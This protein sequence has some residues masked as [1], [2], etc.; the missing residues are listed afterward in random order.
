MAARDPA[1]EQRFGAAVKGL[2][3]G[4]PCYAYQELPSTMDAAHELAAHDAPEGTCVWAERQ[5]AGRGRSGRAWVSPP[6]GVYLS[7]ILR[8]SR[9]SVELPQL[10][11][12]AGLAAAEA[13][14][15]LTGLPAAIRWPNDVLLHDRKLVGI[16]TEAR[17]SA[18][19]GL[20]IN[21]ATAQ[22]D[23][24]DTAT[25][26]AQWVNR[27][28]DRVAVAGA[29]LCRLEGHYRVWNR[30]G[31]AA[32]RPALLERLGL[33]GRFVHITTGAGTFEGQAADVDDSGRLLL[34]LDAGLVRAFDAGEVA[35]LRG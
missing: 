20:G 17:H 15:E 26:L 22:A 16:L 29:L 13:I 32:V 1:I 35:L 4:K 33:F 6:G 14:H 19:I 21:V 8:P 11:L 18:V 5:T 9:P 10:T 24:P 27:A 7:V 31:F 3:L 23:L 12:V 2:R 30:D 34:R 28:P 25:S